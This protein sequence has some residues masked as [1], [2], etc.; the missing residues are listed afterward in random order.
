MEQLKKVEIEEISFGKTSN[1]EYET[2]TITVK[3]EEI[4]GWKNAKTSNWEIG[5]TVE[6]LIRKDPKYGFKFKL[7]QQSNG[8]GN[9]G[10]VELTKRVES[11]EESVNTLLRAVKSNGGVQQ[12]ELPPDEELPF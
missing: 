3:G 6:I 7:P 12:E 9:H 4:Y 2:C 11:L 1:G 8:F 10:L 5:D